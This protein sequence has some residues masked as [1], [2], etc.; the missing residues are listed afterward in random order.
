MTR[1]VEWYSQSFKRNKIVRNDMITKI[2]AALVMFVCLPVQAGCPSFQTVPQDE[3]TMTHQ[4][5]N[6][7][8]QAA[9]S[10]PQDYSAVMME[11]WSDE[12]ANQV[13]EPPLPGDGLISK[14]DNIKATRDRDALSYQLMK[15]FHYEQVDGKVVGNSFWIF[16]RRVGTLA[17]GTKISSPIAGRFILQD[18]K[19]VDVRLTIDLSTL[20]EFIAAQRE[21]AASKAST[22]AE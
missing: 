20:T 5:A 18:Q 2:L 22:Q 16:Y 4:I 7:V 1:G 11:L 19:I 14:E 9:L 3:F 6:R 15:D 10:S 12:G 21:W 8:C 17:N 13:H